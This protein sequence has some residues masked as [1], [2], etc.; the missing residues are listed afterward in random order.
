MNKYSMH[1]MSSGVINYFGL[2]S[3]F[4]AFMYAFVCP[5]SFVFDRPIGLSS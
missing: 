4:S 5:F 2:T 3:I 1:D